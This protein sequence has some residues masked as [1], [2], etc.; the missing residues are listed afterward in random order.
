MNTQTDDESNILEQLTTLSQTEALTENH[1]LFYIKKVIQSNID[2]KERLYEMIRNL[3][4]K[5]FN[6]DIP[7]H[8][9]DFVDKKEQWQQSIEK[10]TLDS[11]LVNLAQQE[12]TL[13][14]QIHQIR[15]QPH[16][17]E[18][19][20]EHVVRRV[21]LSCLSFFLL[22]IFFTNPQIGE[23]LVMSGI[24]GCSLYTMYG[25][26]RDALNPNISITQDIRFANRFAI[27]TCFIE[28]AL[29]AFHTIIPDPMIYTLCGFIVIGCLTSI[30]ILVKHLQDENKAVKN[31]IR[32]LESVNVE[33]DLDFHLTNDKVCHICLLALSLECDDANLKNKLIQLIVGFG[34]NKYIEHN[35]LWRNSIQNILESLSSPGT[36]NAI[37]E[38]ITLRLDNLQAEI[39]P[40]QSHCKTIANWIHLDLGISFVIALSHIFLESSPIMFPLSIIL[41]CFC[42]LNVFR[43]A[44]LVVSAS[45]TGQ[46]K[47]NRN[48]FKILRTAML[49]TGS[50][51]I[52]HAVGM[53]FI[54]DFTIISEAA[55]YIIPIS[56]CF[57][58][59]CIAI[60]SVQY[61]EQ[62][63]ESRVEEYI[64]ARESDISTLSISSTSSQSTHSSSMKHS[65]KDSSGTWRDV[66]PTQEKIVKSKHHN[67]EDEGEGE[68]P[69]NKKK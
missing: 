18:T 21:L 44:Q 53:T 9:H 50:V 5:K 61:Y 63:K 62:T 52:L 34:D 32:I 38:E 11:E 66:D 24:L 68:S 54:P 25:A 55:D 6:T 56:L 30:T 35:T 15:Q 22:V 28:V 37:I 59:A 7:N 64:E 20:F 27:L 58:T 48:F 46:N 1:F 49:F 26:A 39:Q 19:I 47:S 41:F 43:N 65:H 8:L 14:D 12:K 36:N 13:R 33:S 4:K 31:I 16:T 57:C 3:I 42:S 29:I 2:H 17:D 67:D 40:Q 51:I 69:A 23:V 45:T 60:F 10:T